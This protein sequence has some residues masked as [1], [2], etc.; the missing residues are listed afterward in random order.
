MIKVL[1][2]NDDGIDA[3]GLNVL[4]EALAEMADVY[5][6]APK[7]QQSGK[8]QSITFRRELKA[9]EREL[10]GAVSAWALDGTP[11]DCVMW[12]IGI[13][14]E[15]GIRPD[16]IFSGINMG[17]NNGLAAYYSGTVA[18]AREGAINGIRSIAPSLAPATE[19]DSSIM[20][21]GCSL[22]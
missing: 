21:W 4:V 11:A 7:D 15:E 13:L 6:V 12:G 8:S 10:K 20:C 14:A 5:V 18:G 9:D 17:Y 22:S 2:T 3:R 16:F 19:P 1:V